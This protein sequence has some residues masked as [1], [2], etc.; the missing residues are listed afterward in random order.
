[1][2]T[3]NNMHTFADKHRIILQG[4]E[5]IYILPHTQLQ[6]YIADYTITAPTT[7]FL[8]DQTTI[9]SYG[10]A[11]IVIEYDVAGLHIG[12]F[13]P[14][15]K[16]CLI[17]RSY[18]EI[19]I[20]VDFKPAGLYALT[21]I[22]QSELTDKTFPLWDVNFA[23]SKLL[24]EAVERAE[25]VTELVAS[26]DTILLENMYTAYPSQLGFVLQNVLNS[27]GN[28]NVKKLS[29]DIHYSERHLNRM[30]QQYVGTNAKMFARLVRMNSA[31]SLLQ[32]FKHS[33]A[34]VSELAG[35][36]DPSH[37]VRDFE[38]IC[39]ITPKA[40]RDNMSDFHNEIAMSLLYN[41]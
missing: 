26:I 17:G 32:N 37:F 14:S 13:G 16:P 25:N 20:T 29:N 7:S 38:L 12:L 19:I 4:D 28:I 18:S 21:G 9:L 8:S 22:N 11:T 6:A 27:A 30:F 2:I 23:L 33:I 1:M 24:L 41:W 3:K 39:G 10:S 15:I 35:F 34:T 36:G 5:F 40:Y 31:C